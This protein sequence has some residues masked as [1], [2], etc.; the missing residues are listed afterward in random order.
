MLIIAVVLKLIWS[1]TYIL[2]LYFLS[3]LL[4]FLSFSLEKILPPLLR[5]NHTIIIET[6]LVFR[7][8]EW[9]WS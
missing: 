5:A 2:I 9:R 8:E 1:Y 3:F 7:N 4:Y 6:D